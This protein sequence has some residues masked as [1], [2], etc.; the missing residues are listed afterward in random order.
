MC[1][2]RR[3]DHVAAEAGPGPPPMVWITMPSQR[4]KR[5]AELVSLA[6]TV[7]SQPFIQPMVSLPRC[8]DSRPLSITQLTLSTR[9]SATGVDLV[10]RDRAPAGEGCL[11]P[12]DPIRGVGETKEEG[13]P[14]RPPEL[15]PVGSA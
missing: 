15:Q 4:T 9:A 1:P 6:R 11:A 2:S 7:R 8:G 13:P 3:T 5:R 10:D 14:A 12:T